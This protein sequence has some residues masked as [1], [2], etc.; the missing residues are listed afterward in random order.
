M[1]I[2]IQ[3]NGLSPHELRAGAASPLSSPSTFHTQNPTGLAQSV[4]AILKAVLAPV[5]QLSQACNLALAKAIGAR[6]YNTSRT[7]SEVRN[8]MTV[9]GAFAANVLRNPAGNAADPAFNAFEASGLAAL[10][11]GRDF[12]AITHGEGPDATVSVIVNDSVNKHI[13]T[14]L[15][16]WNE[17]KGTRV[18]MQ[19]DLMRLATSPHDRLVLGPLKYQATRSAAD[20]TGI[21][22]EAQ[23][24]EDCAIHA[25]NAMVGGP[26]L[27]KASLDSA[28]ISHRLARFASEAPSVDDFYRNTPANAALAHI[29]DLD[30]GIQGDVL[31]DILNTV[32]PGEI[33]HRRPAA[34]LESVEPVRQAR[35]LDLAEEAEHRAQGCLLLQND[36]FIA[37]RKSPDNAGWLM[38]DSTQPQVQQMGPF[39]YLNQSVGEQYRELLT[40]ESP[41]RSLEHH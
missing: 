1:A 14:A 9:D 37:F 27:N 5:R 23:R 26:V 16:L 12:I 4:A 30:H 36:H 13:P 38:I 19:A 10:I 35:L 20:G 39:A 34:E 40:W 11:A 3:S 17:G 41:A 29:Y 18:L 32:M 25:F 24:G 6:D 28:L 2:R 33:H 15:T 7:G 8:V 31:A 21:Y 22:H